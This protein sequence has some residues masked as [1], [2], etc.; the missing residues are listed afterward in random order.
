MQKNKKILTVIII[1]I[2][3][4][5]GAYSLNLIKSK[6]KDSSQNHNL[7]ANTFNITLVYPEIKDLNEQIK[8][9]Q[10]GIE[11]AI[12]QLNSSSGGILKK[13]PQLILIG[14][15]KLNTFKSDQN[16]FTNSDMFIVLGG[17]LFIK[18]A[19]EILHPLG[20]PLFYLGFGRCKT[21]LNKTDS[22]PTPLIYGLGLTWESTIEPLILHLIEK[23]YPRGT[24]QNEPTFSASYFT[25]D[26]NDERELMLEMKT[27]AENLEIS[28]AS[29]QYFD[30]RIAEYFQ[31][32]QKIISSKSSFLF[33]SNPFI[34]G[35]NFMEQAFQQSLTK[36]L[37]VAGLGTFEQEFV[38][39]QPKATNGALTIS[40]YYPEIKTPENENFLKLF[41]EISPNTQ[42]SDLA[43]TAY[44]AVLLAAATYQKMNS[45]DNEL[46]DKEIKNIE[47][48][49][50][51][52]K[53]N[54]NPDNNILNQE[55]FIVKAE[56]GILKPVEPLAVAIHPKLS[57]CY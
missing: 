12:K 54:I 16:S 51:N 25:A 30:I 41:Q 15:D 46:F 50:P 6:K 57:G 18:K 33:V 47:L 7:S 22:L 13:K 5:C 19:L 29:E 28:T 44:G 27:T 24:T 1:L 3:L 21:L 53:V 39:A 38:S 23:A 31:A 8:S 37:L 56:N 40:N 43:A 11:A 42:A 45:F 4:L 9:A 20:K 36:D 17:D 55:H 49:F 48:N 32:I 14:S 10:M 26:M 35:Q 52:G 2:A 34:A